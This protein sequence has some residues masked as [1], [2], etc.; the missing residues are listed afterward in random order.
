MKTSHRG[1]I[2]LTAMLGGGLLLFLCASLA[3][4][5]IAWDRLQNREVTL[6]ATPRPATEPVR[7]A[8]STPLPI[9]TF[10]VNLTGDER[11]NPL[12]V[13]YQR[14]NP[15]VVN[16]TVRRSGPFS[17]EHDFFAEGQ[18]SG[19]VW[20]KAGHIVTNHHVVADASEVDV[21]FWNDVTVSARVIGADPDSDLA[22]V[23]VDMSPDELFPA[24]L[25]DSDTVQVG[26]QAIAIGNPF[27]YEGTMTVGII[28]AVG[29]SIPATTGFQIPEA[30]Q[31]DAA[32]NPGNSGGPLLDAQGRVIGINAQ[33]RSEVRANSGVG[34]AIPVNL[35]K[36][37]VPALI[38]RGQYEH[39][40]LGISGIPVTP[41]MASDLGLSAER[42]VLIA[43]VIRNSP[44]ERAGLR[45]GRR[46]VSYKGRQIPVDGDILV[47]IDD[48]TL[49]NFD[50]LLIYLSRYTSPGQEVR[51]TVMRGD[52]QV[53][54]SVTLGMRPSRVLP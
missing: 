13:V 31:T 5:L 12:T 25:G 23:K 46:T 16:I 35:A 32:I 20:D 41:S 28:S 48:Q 51:L 52:R 17:E 34:F 2:F 18:G 22:V 19:F 40:W 10:A 43:E 14:V 45:P 1:A 54:I 7:P 53:E 50:D 47:R 37:V 29:R 11:V 49:N 24:E 15:S 44:A 27:G 30:I 3:L 39:P 4:V 9:A 6:S 8:T 38:E 26:E 42:G 36:R 21:T 33:I